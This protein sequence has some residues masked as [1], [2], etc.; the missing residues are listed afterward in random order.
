MHSSYR[1]W[2]WPRLGLEACFAL[3]SLLNE[4]SLL[5]VFE[6]FTDEYAVEQYVEIFLGIDRGLLCCENIDAFG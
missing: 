4:L 6:A 2:E 3:A 5:V 1:R